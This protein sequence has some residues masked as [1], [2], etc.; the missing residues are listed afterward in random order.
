MLLFESLIHK[1]QNSTPALLFQSVIILVVITTILVRLNI[2]IN[3]IFFILI[4]CAFSYYWLTYENIDNINNK[5]E[6]KSNLSNLSARMNKK[7]GLD[8]NPRTINNKHDSVLYMN[9]ALVKIFI[10]MCPFARFST[11]NFKLAL[12]AANQLVRVYESAKLGQKI[13][14]QTIDIAEELQREVLNN[15]QA[16]LNS[17]PSTI[18]AD[19][20]FQANLDILQKILQKIID[21]IKLIYDV[22]YET[23]GP[24]IYS[25]PPSVRAGPWSNPL[26]SKEYNQY[27]NFYY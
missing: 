24:N 4:A 19:Y 2:S 5:N 20:R 27:W 25:P 26:D 17:F 3:I 22:E 6:N 15:M 7:Y 13:P 16:I 12:L 1:L 8:I 18:I 11:N 14:N 10:K 9:P 21:D 23:N